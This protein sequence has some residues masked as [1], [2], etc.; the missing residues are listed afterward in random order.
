[1]RGH[2]T[3]ARSWAAAARVARL[4]RR[5]R[6]L[7]VALLGCASM[8]AVAALIAVRGGSA[9]AGVVGANAEAVQAAATLLAV[10]A[11][12]A[13]EPPRSTSPL[14]YARQLKA[15]LLAIQS[16][17]DADERLHPREGKEKEDD[18]SPSEA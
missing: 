7:A 16:A 9:L 13:F 10:L 8:P 4:P 14:A 6:W 2:H 17:F 1:M 12:V 18:R 11:L 5:A 15:R 3:S